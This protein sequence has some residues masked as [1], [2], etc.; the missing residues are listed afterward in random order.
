MSST[1]SAS[2]IGSV[3]R[4]R[5]QIERKWVSN[6]SANWVHWSPSSP[7]QAFAMSTLA[8][9][10]LMRPSLGDEPNLRCALRPG[11]SAMHGSMRRMSVDLVFPEDR[12]LTVHTDD[13]ASLHVSVAG[14][15]PLVV[16]VHGT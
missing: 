1:R 16:L 8:I 14:E 6:S 3:S 10:S 15:G 4:K 5:A 12:T 9:R 7:S 13:G 2:A 11:D